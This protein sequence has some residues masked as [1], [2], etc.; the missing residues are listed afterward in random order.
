[1]S[2]AIDVTLQS[3]ST[4]EDDIVEKKVV[5]A[6]PDGT[7]Y[8]SVAAEKTTVTSDVFQILFKKEG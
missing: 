8:K 3:L 1:V 7:H 4:L 5:L 6:F 2:P